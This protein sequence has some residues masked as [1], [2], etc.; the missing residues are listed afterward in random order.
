M[1]DTSTV[2]A[3]TGEDSS[4]Y[5][6]FHNTMEAGIAFAFAFDESSIILTAW[7]GELLT[8]MVSEYLVTKYQDDASGRSSE[9]ITNEALSHS[10]ELSS[11]EHVLEVASELLHISFQKLVRL[12]AKDVPCIV[13]KGLKATMLRHVHQAVK[14]TVVNICRRLSSPEFVQAGL[15]FDSLPKEI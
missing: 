15:N 2:L 11:I 12:H 6:L 1:V 9:E 14:E 10:V 8:H 13:L 7:A 3:L 4:L 5:D